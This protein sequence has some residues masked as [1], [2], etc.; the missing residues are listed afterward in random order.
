MVASTL[1]WVL[2]ALHSLHCTCTE[3]LKVS[4]EQSGMT[5]VQLAQTPQTS[6]ESDG[7][8]RENFK[9]LCTSISVH[10]DKNSLF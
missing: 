2:L 8:G 10:K 5:K 3:S 6:C 9:N 7:D 1:P 4:Y